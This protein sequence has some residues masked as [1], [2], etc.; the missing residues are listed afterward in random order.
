M[1]AYRVLEQDVAELV[2]VPIPTP[3]AGQVLVKIAGCGLCH[4]DISMIEVHSTPQMPGPAFTLGHESA[5]HVAAFGEGVTGLSVGDAVCVYSLWSSCG[6]C[7]NCEAGLENFCSFAAAPT[8]G[9]VGQDGGLAEYILVPEQRFVIP[10][11][12]VDPRSAGVLS[13]AGVTTYSAYDCIRPGLRKGATI[14]VIG[15]GGLGCMAIQILRVCAD[16]PRIVAI[17]ANPVR[18]D[19]ARDA[20]ADLTLS[21]GESLARELRELTGDEGVDVVVDCVGTDATLELGRRALR[22]NGEFILVGAYGGTMSLNLMGE[23]LGMHFSSVLNGGTRHMRALIDLIQQGRLKLN[24]EYFPL[25]QIKHAYE[26]M[27]SGLLHGRAV[28]IPA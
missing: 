13:C 18:F 2:D 16:E 12:N 6:K 23:P 21:P 24:V 1:K 15:A 8:G 14:V 3:G 11:G 22:R 10:L 25:D 4:S 7:T 26:K 17:D 19:M 20:G 5:G 9:G 27:E 28:C